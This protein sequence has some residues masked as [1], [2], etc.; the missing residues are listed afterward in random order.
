MPSPDPGVPRPPEAS[1]P[2]HSVPRIGRVLDLAGLLVLLAGAGTLTRAW[3]GF[4]EIRAN[5]GV[6]GGPLWAA[7]EL[8][9]RYARLQ[10]VG[11]ALTLA[12]VA[13]FFV[14]W[15]VARRHA[16]L[17]NSRPTD[18]LSAD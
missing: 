6:V 13:L 8:H 4:Q 12:A 1:G 17:A 11:V 16:S 10:D 2:P 9:D 7:L 18:R 15:A 3:M 14:A 5:E